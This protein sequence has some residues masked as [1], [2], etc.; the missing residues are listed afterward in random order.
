MTDTTQVTDTVADV[1]K[2]AQAL[3]ITNEFHTLAADAPVLFKETKAGYKTTEFWV[4][5]VG[6]AAV[7][8][9]VLDIPGKYGKTITTGALL[10]AY[11]LSRGAAKSGVPVEEPSP[12]AI[13]PVDEVKQ[14]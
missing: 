8:L 3:A 13:A 6:A 10:V 5:L 11:I 14:R 12:V 2:D 9:S 4:A 7:Q 1:A